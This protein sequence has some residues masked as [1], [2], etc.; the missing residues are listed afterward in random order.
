MI[1]I[2]LLNRYINTFVD[3][4]TLRP[5]RFV[6]ACEQDPSKYLPPFQ[7][8]GISLGITF[9]LFAADITLTMIVDPSD[10]TD[11]VGLQSADVIALWALTVLVVVTVV[12]S[13]FYRAVSRLWPIRGKGTFKSI[14][15]LQCYTQ[16]ILIPLA[17]VLFIVSPFL[18]E[19][20]LSFAL[21]VGYFYGLVTGF[22]WNLPAVAVANGVST[23]RTIAGL[24]FWV[25]I[26]ALVVVA[27]ARVVT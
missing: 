6:V 11:T 20:R 9:A 3:F 22:F 7:F 27:V 14:F 17:A 21:V 2:E 25:F 10:A 5:R 8:W 12:Y 26:V 19:N 18:G 23:I 16:A 1:S 4:W 15:S 24:L 13:L